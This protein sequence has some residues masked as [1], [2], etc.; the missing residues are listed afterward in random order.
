[1]TRAHVGRR[2]YWFQWRRDVD[3]FC[4][5]C[6]SCNEF[7]RGRTPPKQ[8]KLIPLTLGAPVER[9]ACDLAGRFPK[10]SSGNVY[11]LTAVCVFTKFIVLVSLRDKMAISV[12]RALM[13]QVFLKFGARDF[14]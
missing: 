1:M 13:K 2:A 11:I 3:I 12:A 4:G 9:W 6:D 7:H 14:D 8:G 10:F 5:R